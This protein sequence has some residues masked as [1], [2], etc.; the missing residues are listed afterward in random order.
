M[1]HKMTTDCQ[2]GTSISI[3][4]EIL[5]H[6]NALFL[7]L[8]PPK[9]VIPQIYILN[10]FRHEWIAKII[11][12]YMWSMLRI[13][14]MWDPM[15][16]HILKL[17]FYLPVTQ[18]CKKEHTCIG[19]WCS[20]CY[21]FFFIKSWIKITPPKSCIWW[22]KFWIKYRLG[23]RLLCQLEQEVVFST[24]QITWADVSSSTMRKC[25]LQ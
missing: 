2:E 22:L 23:T 11:R 12:F 24:W 10:A 25:L 19:Q 16:H 4:V 21:L 8:S 18:R 13:Q 7:D 3:S 5:T 6:L 14:S 17:Y 1:L 15:S 20:E 9:L